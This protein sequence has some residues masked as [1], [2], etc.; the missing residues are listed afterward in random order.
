M[1]LPCRRLL[2]L[3]T[4]NLNLR[5]NVIIFEHTHDTLIHE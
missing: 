1:Q 5:L 2:S 4:Q 3:T